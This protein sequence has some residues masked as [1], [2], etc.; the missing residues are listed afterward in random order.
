MTDRAITFRHL[1]LLASILAFPVVAAEAPT[2]ID[3]SVEASRPATNDLFRATVSAEIT[4]PSIG[5]ITRQANTQI[6]DA[7]KVAKTYPGVKTQ[8]GA[9]NTYPNYSKLGKIESWRIHSELSLESG[10]SVALSEL[11]GKLQTS[12]A[13]SNVVMQPSPET[14]KKAEN[15]AMLDALGAFKARA[16]ILADALDKP[17]HIKKMAVNTSGRVVQPMYRAAAKAMVSEASPM[18]IEAGESQVSVNISGQVELE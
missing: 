6:A 4:G 14:R 10:D 3:L 9:S 1:A 2:V 8:S 7:L 15:E 13:V 5:E 17:Y 18:P 11:L 12:L 16:K